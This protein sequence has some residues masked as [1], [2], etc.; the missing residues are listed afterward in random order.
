GFDYL[1]GRI[2]RAPKWVRNLGLEWLYRLLRQLWRW[3]RQLA[4]I[5]FTWL[6]LKERFA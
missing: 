5:K 6:V 4:L 3:R 1:S 2:P